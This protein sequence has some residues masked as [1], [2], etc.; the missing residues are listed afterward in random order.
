MDMDGIH[1]NWRPP[2][3]VAGSLLGV[4]WIT[5]PHNRV[6]ATEESGRAWF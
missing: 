1:C 4:T 2:R 3:V 6:S 5:K